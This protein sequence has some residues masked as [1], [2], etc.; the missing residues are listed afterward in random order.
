LTCSETA[1]YDFLDK[2]HFHMTAQTVV[3]HHAFDRIRSERGL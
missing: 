1:I 2:G 3:H